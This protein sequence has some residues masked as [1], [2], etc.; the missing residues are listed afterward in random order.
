MP[1][2][3]GLGLLLPDTIQIHVDH[4]GELMKPWGRRTGAGNGE[5]ERGA[6][7]VFVSVAMVAMIGSAALAVDIGQQTAS[8]RRLQ[9]VADAIAL[10]TA[11][12]VGGQT[13]SQL[14]GSAEL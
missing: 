9:A 5:G 11:R 3:P 1:K 6:V 13:V 10:D 2:L 4:A 14:S 8:N 12:A 7:L